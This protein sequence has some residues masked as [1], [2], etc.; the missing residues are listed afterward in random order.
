MRMSW[1]CEG[2][3]TDP[4]AAMVMKPTVFSG[5]ESTFVWKRVVTASDWAWNL[6]GR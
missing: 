2:K 1:V 3:E 4:L 6:F 5:F